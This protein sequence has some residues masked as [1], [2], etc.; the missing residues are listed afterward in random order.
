MTKD[1]EIGRQTVL[2][3]SIQGQKRREID[4]EI[5]KNLETAAFR[6]NTNRVVFEE[7]GQIVTEMQAPQQS[8]SQGADQSGNKK[9]KKNNK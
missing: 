6:Q 4:G 1:L 8:E 5:R 2:D 7:S 3:L 9:K